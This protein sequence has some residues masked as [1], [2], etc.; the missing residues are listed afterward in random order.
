MF[1]LN[2]RCSLLP[3][4]LLLV[5]FL[6]VRASSAAATYRELSDRTRKRR[7]RARDNV[8]R[9]EEEHPAVTERQEEKFYIQHFLKIT[10]Q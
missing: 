8:R 1:A 7:Q 4:S 2:V 9:R 3:V 5:M 6:A 10:Y